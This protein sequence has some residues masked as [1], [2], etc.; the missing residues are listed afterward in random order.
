MRAHALREQGLPLP[1][2]SMLVTGITGGCIVALGLTTL[3]GWSMGSVTLVQ[4]RPYL[5]PMQLSTALGFLCCGLGLV[6]LAAGRVRLVPIVGLLAATIGLWALGDSIFG[7]GL[8]PDDLL[9]RASVAV[10]TFYLGRMAPHTALCFL[11]AGIT[12]AVIHK[13]LRSET[14]RLL[15]GLSGVMVFAFGLVACVG[16]VAGWQ[17]TYSWKPFTDMA[18]HTAAG[19][20]VLSLGMMAYAWHQY[21]AEVTDTV[22]RLPIIVGVGVIITAVSLWQALLVY[23]HV[24]VRKTVA[25]A[26]T[27][28]QTDI[29]EQVIFRIEELVRVAARWELGG[30]PSR[31]AW[32]SDMMRYQQR[33]PYLQAIMW[34]DPTSHVRW[35]QPSPNYEAIQDRPLATTPPQRQILDSA[36]NSREVVITRILDGIPPSELQII[37]PLFPQEGFDGFLISWLEVGSLFKHI[38]KTLA[39]DFALV[40]LDGNETIYGYRQEQT[41]LQRGWGRDR[42]LSPPGLT[43]RLQIWPTPELLQEKLSALPAIILFIG[44]AT[45]LLLASLVHFAQATQQRAVQLGEAN[46]A[47]HHEITERERAET[48]LSRRLEQLEVLRT[49]SAEMTLELD[50]P[51]L[52]HLMIHRATDLIPEAASGAIFLWHEEAG[53][54]VPHVWH[55]RDD[56]M[57]DVKLELGEGVAGVVA[58]R[59][60]GLRVNNYRSSPYRHPTFIEHL[61]MRALIAEPLL[62]KNRLVGVIILDSDDLGHTF[63]AADSQ[64]LALF[65]S[66]AT[67]AITNAQYVTERQQQAMLLLQSNAALQ[68]EISERQQAEETLRRQ[69]EALYQSEKLAAMSGLLASVAHE[70]NN[71]LTAITVRADLL[72]EESTDEELSG[73][74]AEINQAAA[75]CVRMVR[76]FLTLA[77]QGSPERTSVRFNE[78]IEDAMQ[79]L[80]PPLRLDNIEIEIDLQADLPPLWADP[81]QL[82]QVVINLL[83]NAQQ[84][85]HETPPPRQVALTTRFE[86]APD[87]VL[88][89][90]ADNGPGM[91]PEL[92]ERI[93]EPFFTTKPPGVGTGLGLSLCQ[94]IIDSHSGRLQV[95]TRSG[96]GTVFRV[97]LPVTDIPTLSVEAAEPDVGAPI[98]GKDLLIVDDEVGTT[99]A[100]VRLF[101]RDGHR[102]ETAANGREALDKVRAQ[103]YDLILCD[104]RMPELDGPSF[105]RAVA[106]QHPHLQQRFIFLTGDT[107]SP[108][109]KTFLDEIRSPFLAKPF[110]AAEIRRVVQQ[111]LQRLSQRQDA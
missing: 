50:L 38:T 76:Y 90:V 45:A 52:L 56:W 35:V 1:S 37:A 74:A 81:H 95:E 78:V 41:Q 59:R 93:F 111:A 99:K 100:L 66:Q 89:E 3:I 43:W 68:A 28:I 82:H 75:R 22:S 79:V 80:A 105:Y 102:T 73:L 14:A 40:I 104:L 71:P 69:Q 109:A 84:A 6:A 8:G 107:L 16:Y 17:T 42:I 67:I 47:L 30:P 64:V 48:A 57:R 27:N 61:G 92:Q 97:E 5:A 20:V 87:R 101:N 108:G 21:R 91:S 110:R 88:F 19:F 10:N 31:D 70:L 54:L 63:S 96:H 9:R 103:S 58:Q 36:R 44:L 60:E 65:A 25:L 94:G 51:M 4:V 18:I 72:Q 26:A 23:E 106:C 15:P 49:M 98:T 13:P 7:L 2:T 11:L 39:Q 24:L 77:R 83:T 33:D 29:V 34:V 32:E 12:L 46:Q 55:N 53:Q 86:A 85:L 62:Y